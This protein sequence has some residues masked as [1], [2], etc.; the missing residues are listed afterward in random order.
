[1]NIPT[2]PTGF[3]PTMDTEADKDRARLHEIKA[4]IFDSIERWDGESAEYLDICRGIALYVAWNS[5]DGSYPVDWADAV[6][7][8]EASRIAKRGPFRLIKRARSV[9]GQTLDYWH[10]FHSGRNGGSIWGAM[11]RMGDSF[12]ARADEYVK[13]FR[14]FHAQAPSVGEALWHKA[15]Y[16]S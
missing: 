11:G 4:W 2:D 5:R 1:M 8:A 7:E 12:S 14:A 15:F 9:D 10:D 3:L 13:A 16:G 6:V